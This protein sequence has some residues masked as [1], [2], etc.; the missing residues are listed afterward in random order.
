MD[1]RFDLALWWL[2]SPCPPVLFALWGSLLENQ[3]RTHVLR[4]FDFAAWNAPT[5]MHR[6]VSHPI[7]ILTFACYA[8]LCNLAIPFT[9]LLSI[10]NCAVDGD[11]IQCTSFCDRYAGGLIFLNHGD[12]AILTVQQYFHSR[13]KGRTRSHV[14]PGKIKASLLKY[15]CVLFC[16][17]YKITVWKKS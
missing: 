5:A 15:L 10:D 2:P 3:D 17:A 1:W 11:S 9:S 8:C 6:L 13:E 7:G 16:K 12:D 14:F 4:E